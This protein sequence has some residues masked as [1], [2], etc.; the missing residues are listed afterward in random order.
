MTTLDKVKT[1]ELAVIKNINTSPD[2]KQRLF[3]IGMLPLTQV[4][5]LHQSPS[6]NP[7]AYLVRGTVIALRNADATEIFVEVTEADV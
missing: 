1:G 3:D 7:R 6:G 5:V 2:L 4:K